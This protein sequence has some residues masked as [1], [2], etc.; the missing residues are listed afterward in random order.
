MTT[1]TNGAHDR[2]ERRVVRLTTGVVGLAVLW[3]ATVMWVAL[4]RPSVPPVLA[5]ERLEI[6]EP[7]GTLAFVLANSRR[8]AVTTMDGQVLME[9]QEEQRQAPNFIFFDGKGDEVGGML[10]ATRETE[11]GFNAGRHL[12]LDGYKQDQTV[13]LAHYQDS[14]GAR[15]GLIVSDRPR[16]HSLLDALREL[17]L[18]AGATRAEME[19]AIAAIPQD[20]REARM[21]ELFGVRRVFVGS[22]PEDIASLTLRDGAGR[23]RIALEVPIEGEPSIRILDV[24]GETVQRLPG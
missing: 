20:E 11:D 8:P 14:D 21:R 1:E 2:L 7:D 4:R 16:Q 18:E 13:V 19:E 15:S 9:G 17:G 6:R 22:T 3:L 10:F 23:P 5:V 12:S 24:E